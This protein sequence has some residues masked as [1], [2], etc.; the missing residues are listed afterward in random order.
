[1]TEIKRKILKEIGISKTGR[2]RVDI[3]PPSKKKVFLFLFGVFFIF[4]ILNFMGC[5]NSAFVFNYY[6][7][8][9]LCCEGIM[10]RNE[11]RRIFDHLI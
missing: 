9:I 8:Y 4:F 3:G 1:M 7:I 2:A 11:L 6:I 10:K 5:C